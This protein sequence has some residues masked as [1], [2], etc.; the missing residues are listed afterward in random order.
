MSI[1]LICHCRVC[2][3][4]CG[5]THGQ[6]SIFSIRENIVSSHD[7]VN[8]FEPV[9]ENINVLNLVST[10]CPNYCDA[11]EVLYRVPVGPCNVL[12]TCIYMCVSGC[13]VYQWDPISRTI[14][15]KLD[16]SKLVPCSES[17]KSISIEEHLSPGKCQVTSLA[18]LNNELYIGTT[19]GCIVVA[20]RSSMRPITVFR[21]FEEEVRMIVPLPRLNYE[22]EKKRNYPL[23]ATIGRGYRTLIA[24]YTDTVITPSVLSP[25]AFDRD[26]DRGRNMY[27][28]LW[29]AGQWAAA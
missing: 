1:E 15:N 3:L 10:Q 5:E 13:I 29:H 8:H 18:M 26:R 19:W 22:D 20:E 11:G 28:L 16:C 12:V 6:I 2:E 27:A 4:W 21:P 24:R 25:Q 7:I 23:V 17:L 9:I 14:L